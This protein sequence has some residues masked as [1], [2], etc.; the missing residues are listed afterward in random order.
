MKDAL[1]LTQS[2]VCRMRWLWKIDRSKSCLAWKCSMTRE[3]K[4]KLLKIVCLLESQ[5]LKK[6]LINLTKK[7]AHKS[8]QTI[9]HQWEPS[10]KLTATT[11]KK[12]AYLELVQWISLCNKSSDLKLTP[13]VLC[14]QNKPKRQWKLKQI[15]SKKSFSH[16]HQLKLKTK[17]KT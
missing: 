17:L 1:F 8:Y 10:P 15:F 11:L 6:S 2:V 9:N 14:N 16:V 5:A 4:K 7:A 13:K 12:R 3:V